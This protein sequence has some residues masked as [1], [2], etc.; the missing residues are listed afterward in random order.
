[1]IESGCR[2]ASPRVEL[3]AEPSP[4][5]LVITLKAGTGDAAVELSTDPHPDA[6]GVRWV[7]SDIEGWLSTPPTE[8][9][10]TPLGVADR[11]VAAARFPMSAREITVHGTVLTP[12][13]D[14]AEIARHRLYTAFSGYT[15]DI[16]L[17]VTEA[18]PK[19]VVARTAGPVETVPIGPSHFT[20][21]VPLILPDPL[22]YGTVQR[23]DTTDAQAPGSLAVTFPWTFPLRFTSSGD[24]T[25]RMVLVNAG[26][27]P[28]F[29]VSRITGPLPQGWRISNE[30]SEET[31]TFATALGA[32][33]TL[34]IDHAARTA[35]VGGY[36][37][38]ALASGSWWPLLP[39]RN[40]LRFLTPVYDGAASWSVAYHDAYL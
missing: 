28:T 11:A 20:F 31:L 39:G 17:T 5:P 26:S 12:A 24:G 32:G 1:M 38:A 9:I 23:G 16:P 14:T 10:V 19:K 8:P 36:S 25:G 4:Q 30:T 3:L 22:K 40:N 7:L 27:A 2:T 18:V 34:L 33:Q 37:I 6:V 29:P 21:A 35:T 13:F 15:A